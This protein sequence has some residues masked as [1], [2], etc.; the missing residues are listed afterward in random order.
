MFHPK[1]SVG[2]CLKC[3]SL[4]QIILRKLHMV[5]RKKYVRP[6]QESTIRANN[7][8]L[9][10]LGS[11]A[12]DQPG[13]VILSAVD[14][15]YL[16]NCGEGIARMTKNVGI[17]LTNIDHAFFTQ[18]KWNCIGGVTSVIFSTIANSGYPPTF[19]GPENLQKIFQRMS[20]LSTV[21]G[22][23]KHRFNDDL[24]KT[25]RFEDHKIVIEP[26][27]LKH[28]NASAIIYVCKLKECKGSFSLKKSLDKNV[29]PHLIG[30]L[31][32]GESVTLDDGTVVNPND[33]QNEC[34]PETYF[35][36]KF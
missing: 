6:K 12:S 4:P 24:F 27:E 32:R 26:I 33:V 20:F 34:W 18:S 7:A 19:T 5:H 21:G 29:P 36:S 13:S 8:H 1:I 17:S 23:Y 22:T 35:I 10:V 14:T 30:N 11:G 25:E 9:Q 3:F 15:R 2:Y 16:F 28:L 31:H